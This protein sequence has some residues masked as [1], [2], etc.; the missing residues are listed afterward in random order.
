MQDFERIIT[1]HR[2][3][4]FEFI[5]IL[6]PMQYAR[7]IER[8]RRRIG[9]ATSVVNVSNKIWAFIN[10]VYEVSIVYN[11]VQQLTLRLFH[12]ERHVELMLA[13]VYAKCDAIK[14]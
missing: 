7:K 6:E 5:G 12:I 14:E 8:Y 10:D 9:L 11:M 2:R 3:H 4:H 13:L 1:I